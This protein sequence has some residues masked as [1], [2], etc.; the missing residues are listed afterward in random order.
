M[1][2]MLTVTQ[3]CTQ[4]KNIFDAEEMLHDIYIFGE[5]ANFSVSGGNA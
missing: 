2:N 5:V 3:L 4:I 1:N